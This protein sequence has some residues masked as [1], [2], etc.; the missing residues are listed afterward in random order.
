MEVNSMMLSERSILI[1]ED[2]A[3]LRS[4]LTEIFRE[5][6]WRVRS[7]EDG[8]AS[9]Q[10]L[11][12][13]PPA[14]LLSD[15]EMSGMSGFELLSIVRRRFPSIRVVAMSGAFDGSA[16]PAGVAA[17]AFYAKGGSVATLLDIVAEVGGGHLHGARRSDVT[18]WLPSSLETSGPDGS[19]A[20]ACSNCLRALYL[21]RSFG[22]ESQLVCPHCRQRVTVSLLHESPEVLGRGLQTKTPTANSASFGTSLAPG[23]GRQS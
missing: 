2:N 21:A 4:V 18:V 5:Y 10:A 20:V 22:Q 6:G 3:V 8:F 11:A 9:L 15:L 16:V 13:E 14:V 12:E 17:D 23:F 19:L 1:A 7:A